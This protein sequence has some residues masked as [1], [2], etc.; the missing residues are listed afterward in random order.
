MTPKLVGRTFLLSALFT[1]LVPG[2]LFVAAAQE[3]G[4]EARK[5]PASPTREQGVGGGHIPQRG[6]APVRQAPAA[7]PANAVR[8]D[9]PGHP[10]APHVHASNDE[11]V[12]HDTGRNDARFHL[13][14]PWEH[15]RFTQ[16]IG[17][18]HIWRL[19][20]GDRNRFSVGGFY[21]Q[22]AAADAAFV[23]DWIWNDDDIVLYDDPDH[24]GWYLAYNTRLGTYVH[25]MYLGS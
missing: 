1:L 20:G 7:R 6:P 18:Q 15:G 8:R 5:P 10:E 21:F 13:D 22:V 17:A 9:Q 24:D 3:R 11:W 12:G 2:A 25:V 23:G 19:R 4:R 14:H 16:P